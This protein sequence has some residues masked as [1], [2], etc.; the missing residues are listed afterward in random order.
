MP[1]YSSKILSDYDLAQIHAYLAAIPAPPELDRIEPLGGEVATSYSSRED[2]G[3]GQHVY[4]ARCASCH[5]ASGRGG[6]GP[7]LVGVAKRRGVAGVESFVR[8]SSGAMPR[9]FPQLLTESEVQGAG[10]VRS[11]ARITEGAL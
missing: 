9:L 11:K 5:G 6:I 10:A 7:S 8:N 4:V 1:L 3:R 2:A